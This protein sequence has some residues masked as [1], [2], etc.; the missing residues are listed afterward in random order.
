[1]CYFNQTCSLGSV[2]QWTVTWKVKGPPQLALK[3]VK[4]NLFNL[5]YES[6][7][8]Y[9]VNR[10]ILHFFDS[11]K[12]SFDRCKNSHFTFNSFPL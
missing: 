12:P 4:Y 10:I 6:K 9:N 2:G 5:K 8:K 7:I 1:M 3:Y 11:L